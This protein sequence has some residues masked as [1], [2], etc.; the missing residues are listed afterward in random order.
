MAW[1]RMPA[2]AVLLRRPNCSKRGGYPRCAA[3]P[4]SLGGSCWSDEASQLIPSKTSAE[5]VQDGAAPSLTRPPTLEERKPE[6]TAEPPDHEG[7]VEVVAGDE[8]RQQVGIACRTALH[9]T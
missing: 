4:P 6:T 7:Y 3:A 9:S 1:S 8:R 5:E 2:V